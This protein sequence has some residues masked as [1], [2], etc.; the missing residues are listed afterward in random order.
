MDPYPDSSSGDEFHA[1]GT[2]HATGNP[3]NG[4]T[5]FVLQRFAPPSSLSSVPARRQAISSANGISCVH[6]TSHE[7]ISHPPSCKYWTELHSKI[8]AYVWSPASSAWPSWIALLP[9]SPCLQHAGYLFAASFLLLMALSHAMILLDPPPPGNTS[10]LSRFS[11]RPSC[12]SLL[13]ATTTFVLWVLLLLFQLVFLLPEYGSHMV[14][15]H[16]LA[17]T[18][19]Q[20]LSA[21]I[22]IYCL[23]LSAARCHLFASARVF[24]V[25]HAALVALLSA[26]AS[27]RTLQLL[28]GSHAEHAAMLMLWSDAALIACLP[29][30]LLAVWPAVTPGV[31]PA[32]SS[33]PSSSSPAATEGISAQAGDSEAAS[34]PLSE[35]LSEPLLSSH[36]DGRRSSQAA[37]LV[38]QQRQQEQEQPYGLTDYASASTLSTIGFGWIAPLLRLGSSR[39][40]TRADIPELRPQEQAGPSFHRFERCWQRQRE[41]QGGRAAVSWALLR[42]PH[43]ASPI[44]PGSFTTSGSCLLRSASPSSS[45]SG[46]DS[47]CLISWS[48]LSCCPLSRACAILSP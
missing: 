40:L 12:A 36:G 25:A 11:S 37:S 27:L 46:L 3:D 42:A 8:L 5:Y 20:A 47:R 13:S 33:P 29:F 15:L 6:L 26:P 17:F 35:S 18:S 24:M 31:F 28:H 23:L 45:C 14:P 38:Q 30:Q 32:S 43:S 7:E 39:P 4:S 34:V 48:A 41:E 19:V 16:E 10:V 22:S 1:G 21:L 9:F 2:H 44:S